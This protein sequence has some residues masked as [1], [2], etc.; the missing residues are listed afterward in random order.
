MGNWDFDPRMSDSS[1]STKETE[2]RA[3]TGAAQR[4]VTHKKR[5]GVTWGERSLDVCGSPLHGRK[6]WDERKERKLGVP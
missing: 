1:I 5:R 6:L 2:G 4:S 3:A